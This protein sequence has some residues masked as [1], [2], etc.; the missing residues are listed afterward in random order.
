[1][2]N[3]L[4]RKRYFSQWS[5]ASCKY[6]CKGTIACLYNEGGV[7]RIML[8]HQTSGPITRRAYKRDFMVA[9]FV[10]KAF[11]VGLFWGTYF[12]REYCISKW[13]GF[14]NTNDFFDSRLFKSKHLWKCFQD[15]RQSYR[16]HT[17]QW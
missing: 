2:K 3:I 1:M 8:S 11:L 6:C 12:W 16:W 5:V 10:Q 4:T 14:D 15:F 7:T 17:I 13:V 9:A